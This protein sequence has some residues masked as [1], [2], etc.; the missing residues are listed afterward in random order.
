MTMA[1]MLMSAVLT[2]SVKWEVGGALKV[3]AGVGEGANLRDEDVYV[4]CVSWL[5]Y[6]FL[7]R[8]RRMSS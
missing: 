1:P 7:C 5:S 6:P 8:H 3:V 4:A 2:F